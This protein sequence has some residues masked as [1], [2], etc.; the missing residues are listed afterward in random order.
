M[1]SAV[2]DIEV[3]VADWVASDIVGLSSGAKRE[4]LNS[5]VNKMIE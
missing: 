4:Y 3:K 5:Q 2:L 1:K